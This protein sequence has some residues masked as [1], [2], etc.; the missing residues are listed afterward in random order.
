MYAILSQGMIYGL[1]KTVSTATKH[2][3]KMNHE[4]GYLKYAVQLL[5]KGVS[6]G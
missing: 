6:H 1:Y 5:N 2:A 4:V 3:K